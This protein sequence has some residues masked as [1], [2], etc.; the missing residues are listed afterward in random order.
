VLEIGRC[1][2]PSGARTQPRFSLRGVCGKDEP[3]GAGDL[4]CGSR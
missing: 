2:P 1:S 4:P 3:E